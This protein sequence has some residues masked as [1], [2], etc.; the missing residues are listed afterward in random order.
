LYINTPAA[1]AAIAL[2]ANGLAKIPITVPIVFTIPMIDPKTLRPTSPAPIPNT[3]FH[4]LAINLKKLLSFSLFSLFSNQLSA[5][6][7]PIP[8]PINFNDSPIREKI[9]PI[10]AVTLDTPSLILCPT[11]SPTFLT[12]SNLDSDSS[13]LS[14]DLSDLNISFS[15]FS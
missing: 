2:S 11:F 5:N 6:L 9:F 4:L 3:H 15:S 10:G 14:F 12:F 13:C 1:I 7:V 8:K